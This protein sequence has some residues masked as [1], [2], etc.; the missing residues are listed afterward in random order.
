MSD[1][2][3]RPDLNETIKELSAQWDVE[4][5]KHGQVL[6]ERYQ[7]MKKQIENAQ[8][9]ADEK[10]KESDDASGYLSGLIANADAIEVV[11]VTQ[12]RWRQRCK[13]GHGYI[14]GF[15]ADLIP[16]TEKAS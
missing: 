8:V 9:F 1:T 16:P 3:K 7:N 10:K 14:K 12:F 2:N 15:P 6:W 5:T 13:A 4:N 11:M